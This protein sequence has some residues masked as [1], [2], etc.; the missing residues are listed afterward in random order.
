MLYYNSAS[1]HALMADSCLLR[2]GLECQQFI[3]MQF[4]HFKALL[5][6][7]P[8]KTLIVGGKHPEMIRVFLVQEKKIVDEKKPKTDANRISIKEEKACVAVKNV[9]AQ[10]LNI[11]Y[12]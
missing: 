12:I 3:L 2:F 10:C 6:Y 7:P 5:S 11:S 1:L 9:W 4:R 8:Q